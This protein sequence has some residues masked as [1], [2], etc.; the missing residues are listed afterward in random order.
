[1]ARSIQEERRSLE[2]DELA[3]VEKTHHPGLGLLSDQ[4]LAE[5][6]KLVRERVD[7]ARESVARQ[8]RDARAK[9]APAGASALAGVNRRKRDVFAAALKRVNREAARRQAKAA[10]KESLGAAERVTDSQRGAQAH[11]QLPPDKARADATSD[12]EGAPAYSLR[13]PAK[14]GVKNPA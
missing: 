9:T 1:M 13:K 4:D 7:L 8:R 5:L 12:P 14:R 2:G 3:L 10:Q 6:R 11:V